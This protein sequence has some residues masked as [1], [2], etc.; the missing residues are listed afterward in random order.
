MKKIFNYLILFILLLLPIGVFALANPVVDPI[1]NFLPIDK[2]LLK[3]TI[4]LDEANIL[5]T[6]TEEY[7]DKSGKELEKETGIKIF[8]A[9]VPNLSG[10]N[11]DEFVDNLFNY[12]TVTT[13]NENVLIFIFSLEDEVYDIKVSDTLNEA[14]SFDEI[15]EIKEKYIDTYFN[16]DEWDNG[17]KNG[18]SAFYEKIVKFKNINLDYTKPI[19]PNEKNNTNMIL[20]TIIIS[21][22]IIV[23][24]II[25]IIIENKSKKKNK[26][27]KKAK[28]KK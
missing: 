5:S 20:F 1:I 15:D 6:K 17:V 13:E 14:L 8:V 19:N 10:F 18:Y 9:T 26:V 25:C 23:V 12:I 16:N 4:V 27:N 21:L 24:A 22:V 3:N 2:N 11:L 7:I 28:S